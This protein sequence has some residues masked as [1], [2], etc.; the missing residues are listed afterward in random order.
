MPETGY[1]ANKGRGTGKTI[2][3]NIK[4]FF[5][6]LVLRLVRAVGLG[7]LKMFLTATI[8]S[9]LSPINSL[10]SAAQVRTEEEPIPSYPSMLVGHQVQR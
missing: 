1:G 4:Y 8:F 6:A 7:V 9:E 2:N 3:Q 5:L 10:R